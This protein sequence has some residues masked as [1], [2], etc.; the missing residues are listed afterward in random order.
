M[1]NILP[2]FWPDSI[3]AQLLLILG[4]GLITLQGINLMVIKKIQDDFSRQTHYD[5]VRNVS[6]QYYF[7]RELNP[8]QRLEAMAGTNQTKDDEIWNLGLTILPGRPDWA[9]QKNQEYVSET[10][11]KLRERI[12]RKDPLPGPD[13]KIRTLDDHDIS[14][15]DDYIGD[16]LDGRGDI[17]FPLLEV[18]VQLPDGA[19]MSTL[20]PLGFNESKIV[21]IQRLQLIAVSVIFLTLLGLVLVKVTKPIRRLAQAA[22]K[23]GRQPEVMQP[24]P[25]TG[26]REVREAA[27]SFNLMRQRISDN[28]AERDRMLAAM[29][30]DLRTPLTCLQL[31][32]DGASESIRGQALTYC[33][34]VKSIVEQGLELARSLTTTEAKV[35]LGLTALI[36]SLGDDIKASGRQ[37]TWRGLSDHNDEEVYISARPLCLRRCLDNLLDNALRYGEAVEI[38]A[39]VRPEGIAVEIL[40]SGP[41]IPEEELKRVFEPYYRLENSRN[42][43]SGGTGLGLAI[44]RN[45]AILNGAKLTLD[46]RPSG[47][48]RASLIFPPNP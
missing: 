32:L 19:W 6:S 10:L 38:R 33:G 45:M 39:E 26:T 29:A 31:C 12:E 47:G 23:F 21:W 20:Q 24:M 46:N 22:D 43:D 34:R 13:I 25:E 36:D 4:I 30:H 1:K 3:L 11:T 9:V 16:L 2:K 27:H 40:D 8:E 5:L 37:I 44:A 41:G 18:A 28:L 48:L 42:R 17:A 14:V 7:L 15:V 35:S